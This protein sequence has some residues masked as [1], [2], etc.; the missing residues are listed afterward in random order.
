[1]NVYAQSK[2]VNN[3]FVT[4]QTNTALWL[5]R[6]N[7]SLNR[8]PKAGPVSS[9]DTVQDDAYLAQFKFLYGDKKFKVMH[10]HCCEAI[11]SFA[12]PQ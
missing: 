2:H 11:F 4:A 1:V 5:Q 3:Y 7:W 8:P 10:C 9:N 6:H 12:L